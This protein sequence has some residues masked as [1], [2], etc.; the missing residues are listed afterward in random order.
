MAPRMDDC[1]MAGGDDSDIGLPRTRNRS[2]PATGGVGM[3]NS[4]ARRVVVGVGAAVALAVAGAAIAYFTSTGQGT[5]TATVGSA[6]NW[7]V[8]V[9]SA[10]G[11]PLYPGA[12]TQNF[13]YT[14]V[15][16]S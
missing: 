15:N 8:N 1:A 10:S 13:T 5:G 3:F 4:K 9:S 2:Q 6:S 11:G 16:S 7:S 14:V 12:G